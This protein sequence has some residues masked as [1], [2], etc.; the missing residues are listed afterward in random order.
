M[1]GQNANFTVDPKLVAVA[2]A[3]KNQAMIADEVLPRM[4]VGA[5]EFKYPSYDLDKGFTVVKDDVGRTSP[6]NELTW[7]STQVTGSLLDHGLIHK[8]PERDYTNLPEGRTKDSLNAEAVEALQDQILLNREVRAAAIVFAT[9]SYASGHSTTLSGTNQWSHASSN[10]I[11]AI[12]AAMDAGIMPYNVLVLGQEVATKLR[13]N[14][15]I[16]K[17]FNGSTGDSGIVPLDFIRN[18][19][20][21][22]K[23]LVG[24]GWV[25]TAKKGQTPTYSRAW[26]KGAAL[27]HVPA[28][29]QSVNV[30]NFRPIFGFS[31]HNGQKFVGSAFDKDIGLRGGT[32]IRVGEEINEYVVANALGYYWDAAIA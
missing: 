17:A 15:V 14:P 19:F 10:P 28:V 18:L 27:L 9:T 31:P 16:V 20:G 29:V 30:M 25:N 24:Q 12:S 3:Y 22:E 5:S 8:I 1:S 26:G 4:D 23:I 7:R 6:P 32:E 2:L 21:L 13:Q 11:T